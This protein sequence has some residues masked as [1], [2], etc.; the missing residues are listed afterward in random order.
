M[1]MWAC[2]SSGQR[3]RPLR[4]VG[5]IRASVDLELAEL[6]RTQ[7]RVGNHPLHR[8]TDGLFGTTS[9]QVPERLLFVPL[10]VAAVPGVDL[11]IQLVAADGDLAGIEHDHVIA[12]VQVGA[13]GRLVFAH[14]G[15]G[16]PRREPAERL[17][18]ASTTYQRRSISAS[19]SVY[20]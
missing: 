16:D 7:P 19:R 18:L 4:L 11:R 10:R 9:Q 3:F 13:V 5:V 15:A 17:V 12:A 14:E 6:L 1:V 8:A 2:S 20:V